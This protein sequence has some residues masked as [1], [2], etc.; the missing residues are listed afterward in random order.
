VVTVPAAAVFTVDGHD[1]LWLDRDGHAVRVPVDVGVQGQDQ[2]EIR[3]GVGAGDR[4]VV[5]GA[6]RVRAGQSLP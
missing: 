4:V 3:S 1:V 2:V 5:R 6:D